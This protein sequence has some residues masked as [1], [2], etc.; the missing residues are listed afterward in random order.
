VTNIFYID[1][2]LRICR[3]EK[4][5]RRIKMKKTNSIRNLLTTALLI[6]GIFFIGAGTNVYAQDDG[7]HIGSGV[8][9]D[10]YL[11]SGG[12]RTGY[13]GSGLRD[14]DGGGTIGSGTRT[15]DTDTLGSGVGYT[16]DDGG[17]L[18]SGCCRSGLVGS[19]GGS[20]F[21]WESIWGIFSGGF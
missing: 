14:G 13:F 21:S 15:E 17:A 7:G 11:G 1:Y 5:N 6:G 12:G 8:G 20:A 16:A 2:H 4:I 10:G 9:R 3:P 18:G 19:G